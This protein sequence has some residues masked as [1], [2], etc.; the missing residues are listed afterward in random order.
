VSLC[1]ILTPNVDVVASQVSECNPELRGLAEVPGPPLIMTDE[2]AI[3]DGA[4]LA[5]F[6]NHGV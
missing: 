2:L 1:S 3:V 6:S 5:T 4:L